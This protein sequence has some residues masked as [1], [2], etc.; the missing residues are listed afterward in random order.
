MAESIRKSRQLPEEGLRD[1]YMCDNLVVC[2]HP[3]WYVQVE[4]RGGDLQ[5]N[6]L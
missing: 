2:F 3:L 4:K 6:Y 5:D 1:L